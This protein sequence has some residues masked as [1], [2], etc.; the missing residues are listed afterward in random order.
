MSIMQEQRQQVEDMST[1][2][3]AKESF[4]STLT[5]VENLRRTD[6][7]TPAT[8]KTSMV[9]V[10]SFVRSTYRNGRLHVVDR[11]LGLFQPNNDDQATLRLLGED[12]NG[13]RQQQYGMHTTH[14]SLLFF[15]PRSSERGARPHPPRRSTTSCPWYSGPLVSHRRGRRRRS[16]LARERKIAE[17]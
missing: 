1:V 4:L 2:Q 3:D 13:I 8:S 14:R 5:V 17:M 11:I 12:V 15:S 6:P 7:R 16:K 10:H 9:P